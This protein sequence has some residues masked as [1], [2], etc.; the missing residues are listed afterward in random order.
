ML[1]EDSDPGGRSH[2]HETWAALLRRMCRIIDDSCQTQ[3]GEFDVVQPELRM[4]GLMA[5]NGW[6]ETRLHARQVEFWRTLVDELLGERIVLF[7]VDGDTAWS[8][9]EDSPNVRQVAEIA[10]PRLRMALEDSERVAPDRVDALLARFI[11]LHPFRAIEAW[12]FQNT[13]VLRSLCQDLG[14]P[15]LLDRID[16][17]EADRT[18]LDEIDGTDEPKRQMPFGSSHNRQLAGDHFPAT[19]VF[20]AERSFHHA[21]LALAGCSALCDGLRETYAPEKFQ[22]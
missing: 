1:T 2:H 9:R 7:H 13:T 3:P 21:V 20:A 14:R 10:L 22:R 11:P 8:D 5:G 4:R 19:A 18:L 16:A 15:E 17:W 6:R 12:L